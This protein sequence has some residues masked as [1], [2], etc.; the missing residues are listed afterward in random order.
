MRYFN[1][2][3][4]I[5]LVILA[6]IIFMSA[7]QL[8]FGYSQIPQYLCEIGINFF[9]QGRYE[10]ALHE[11]KKALMVQPG[12]GPALKYIEMTQRMIF[13][14]AEEVREIVIPAVKPSAK[15]RPQAVDELLDL[16]EIQRE[17][18][19]GARVSPGKIALPVAPSVSRP[20]A[21]ESALRQAVV[22]KKAY[23]PRVLALDE[24]LSQIRQPIEIEQGES[25]TI[26]GMNIQRFLVT[27]PNIVT[28]ERNGADELSVTGKEL[29]Y[30]YVHIWDNNGRWSTE[31]LTVPPRPIGPTL[32]EELRM[33]EEKA[34]NFRIRYYLD[35]S[36]F[37][38]GRRIYSLKR[39]NYYWRHTASLF[40]ETP[41]GMF[42]S[43]VSASTLNSS[44]DITYITLGLTQGKIGKFKDF[45]LRLL[46]YTPYI[47]NLVLSG[48]NLRGFMLDSPA[49]NKK[50]YYNVYYGR[51]SGGLY[52]G[53]SPGLA[54]QRESYLSGINV[55]IRPTE[56]QNF[57][58][59]VGRGW[60]KDRLPDLHT[61]GYD[62]DYSQSFSK[63]S[64]SS[65]V[66]YDSQRVA[67]LLHSIYSVPKFSLN[68]ELRNI[69][70]NFRSMTGL[71]SRAGELGLL[72]NINYAP[73]NNLNIT[74]R[75]D[76][77]KDRLFPNPK[78]PDTWNEEMSL[79]SSLQVNPLTNLRF[80]YSLQNDLGRI[81]PTRI[82]SAG[83]GLSRY[84]EWVRRINTYIL[85]RY[86]FIRNFSNP[87]LDYVN[88][89]ILTGISFNL[90]KDLNYFFNEELGWVDTIN[91]NQTASPRAFQ[92]GVDF[93]KQVLKTPFF[94]NLRFMYRDEENASSPFSFL[95][96]EDY[97][98]GYGEIT[99]RP[100]PDMEAFFNARVRNVWAEN[101]NVN[102]HIDVNFYSGLRYLWDT[103]IRWESQGTVEGYVF[104]DLNS[105]GLRQ[106]DEAPVEGVKV[107]LG[108]DK[109]QVTDLFGYFKF[110]N[111][112]A[113]KAFVNIDATTLPRGFILTVPATQEAP[114]AQGKA[115][116]INF[117]IISK[118]EISGIVFEDVDGK[119]QLGPNSI[120]VKGVQVFL[121][122]GALATTD[123]FGRYA[124]KKANPGKH[125]LTLDLKTV[126]AVYIPTV[127]IFL[128]FELSEG[129]SFNYNIPLKKTK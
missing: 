90:I 70:R 89:R 11:F 18:I 45:N 108:K 40:G 82:H 97:I 39:S 57:G 86:F 4:K 60:G 22:K 53:F 27:Q 111:V 65:D 52:G 26:K 115:T 7:A 121:E 21:M 56:K 42:D 69:D 83:I 13:G 92:T 64:F 84:I 126:P 31:F 116:V 104:K 14:P 80:D 20:T 103:G 102:K 101:A 35:W 81:A 109:F 119:K 9:Q 32:E 47:S 10:E 114:I 72:T 78:S 16:I 43:G 24:S 17:M 58:L 54:N 44:S 66:G 91:T 96:G 76:L 74:S 23:I 41:Y 98:E 122:D 117:G 3:Q 46:D 48:G 94:I 123:D 36:S 38:T 100:K 73:L 55:N 107:W 87:N 71:V 25:I 118:T 63:G 124:F 68:S 62:A 113:H 85:Y 1:P 106:R 95:S 61:Y 99:Y 33:E 6:A 8:C 67:Y 2:A 112:K 12:Y 75:L 129:Q 128:D 93:N 29:G 77:Y 49:F 110:K 105:D 34:R 15:M 120:G 79:D 88:N 5:I 127:P 37:E 125:R 30:T 28:V 50:L 59:S 19:A 51:E